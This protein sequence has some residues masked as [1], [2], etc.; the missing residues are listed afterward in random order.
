[1][2]L[3]MLL[4]CQ[5]FFNM[6]LPDFVCPKLNTLYFFYWIAHTTLFSPLNESHVSPYL[7]KSFRKPVLLQEFWNWQFSYPVCSKCRIF[8]CFP[9][10]KEE[11]NMKVCAHTLADKQTT[12]L[13]SVVNIFS[14]TVECFCGISVFTDLPRFLICCCKYTCLKTPTM[15]SF[16]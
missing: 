12:Y 4:I 8:H 5:E 16:E 11:E 7:Q 6:Q 10:F 13:Q 9:S 2:R 1:M 3:M 15:W 14:V